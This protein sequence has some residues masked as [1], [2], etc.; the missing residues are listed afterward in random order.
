MTITEMKKASFEALKAEKIRL[1]RAGRKHGVRY[2]NV[3]W[4]MLRRFGRD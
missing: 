1:R 3:S 2:A 4:A